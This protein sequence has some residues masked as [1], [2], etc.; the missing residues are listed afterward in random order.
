MY[1]KFLLT[2]FFLLFSI[3]IFAQTTYYMSSSSGNDSNSGKSTSS[4]WKS[5]DKINSTKF[6]P[7]DKILF[8]KGRLMVRAM[9]Y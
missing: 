1:K 4:P 7:G 5:L 3:T 2:L 6:Y 9:G 8:Q